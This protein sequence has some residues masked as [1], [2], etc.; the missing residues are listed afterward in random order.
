M[1]VTNLPF[2]GIAPHS[3]LRPG[4]FNADSDT[5]FAGLTAFRDAYNANVPGIQAIADLAPLVAAAASYKGPWA[6]LAAAPAGPARALAIPASTT[7][8]D[9]P[10]LLTESV[11]D[12]AAHEPGVSPKWILMKPPQTVELV[13]TVNAAGVASVEWSNFD[14]LA[15]TYAALRLVGEGIVGSAA[16]AELKCGLR[17]SST[18][19]TS[20]SSIY[21]S[22]TAGD[23]S[24]SV[25]GGNLSFA[26]AL[27]NVAAQAL[28]LDMDISAL[29]PVARP[30]IRFTTM[31]GT[32]S[33]GSTVSPSAFGFLL[34]TKA[35][36]PTTGLQGLRIYPSTGTL[37]GTFRLYGVRK[38]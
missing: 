22:G 12:V 23:A 28:A 14:T 5:F 6:T 30:N 13:G 17:Q 26:G 25:A 31:G 37:S 9:K 2:L 11:A 1:S 33:S 38:A 10:W 19:Y 4:T 27:K 32:D 21:T 3:I 34:T 20:G 24:T 7:H 18:W 36:V 15:A 8:L 16:T 35:W 29:T